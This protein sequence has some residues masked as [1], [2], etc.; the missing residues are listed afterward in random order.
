MIFGKGN[1][2]PDKPPVDLFGVRIHFFGHEGPGFR[3]AL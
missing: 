2:L 3:T 1:R